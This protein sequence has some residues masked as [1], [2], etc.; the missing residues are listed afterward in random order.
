[1]W[2]KSIFGLETMTIK[3]PQIAHCEMYHVWEDGHE[4]SKSLE[5]KFFW[6]I[7]TSCIRSPQSL[8]VICYLCL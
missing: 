8:P 6:L 3:Y 4:L 7:I 2:I 5:D 1:M